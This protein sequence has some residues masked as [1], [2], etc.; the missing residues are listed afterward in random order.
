ME[1]ATGKMIIS[2]IYNKKIHD[3]ETEI[4]NRLVLYILR[5]DLSNTRVPINIMICDG[6]LEA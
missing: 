3:V 2:E 6:D 4:K 5:T 1:N